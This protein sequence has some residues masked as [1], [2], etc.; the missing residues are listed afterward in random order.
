MS[1][2]DVTVY[3]DHVVFIL[4]TSFSPKSE[5]LSDKS[6]NGYLKTVFYIL[7]LLYEKKLS[8]TVD[9]HRERQGTLLDE[10]EE[11]AYGM[12]IFLLVEILRKNAGYI[13][14]GMRRSAT[15]RNLSVYDRKPA[16]NC[17]VMPLS[18]LIFIIPGFYPRRYTQVRC[19]PGI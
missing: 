2:L 9:N 12:R 17:A 19:G 6:N 1:I 10:V 14:G 5:K 18:D 4:Y 7:Q 16:D 3:S 15:L 11:Q 8:A 13:A